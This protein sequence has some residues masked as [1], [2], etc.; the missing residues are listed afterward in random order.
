MRF[1]SHYL[2]LRVSDRELLARNAGT[3]W[4][5]LNQVVYAGKQI[6]LGLADCL[7]ALCPGLTL[8]D[9]PLTDRARRQRLIRSGAVEVEVGEA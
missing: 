9:M 5:T 8:D 4:G 6:E 2:G 7:V 1:K 3:T